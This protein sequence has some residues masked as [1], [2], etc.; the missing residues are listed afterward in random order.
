MDNYDTYTDE[1]LIGMLRDGESRLTEVLLDRYKVLVRKKADT[2]YILGA[3]RE[4]LIQEGMIGLFKAIRDFDAGRDASFATFARLCILR[5]LYTAVKNSNRKKHLPLNAYV[6]FYSSLSDENGDGER[7]IDTLEAG[8]QS[9]PE[10]L[11][12]DRENTADL[13]RHIEERLSPLERDVLDLYLTGMSTAEIARVLGRDPKSTDNAL[14]R[15]RAK[16]RNR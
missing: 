1:E 5:Q 14:Q 10:N 15:L 13:W 11:V 3:D 6:S 16:L 7:L 8:A 2:M 12:I 4:D 9:N